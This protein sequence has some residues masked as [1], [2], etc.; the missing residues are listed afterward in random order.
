MHLIPIISAP[1][2]ILILL[3]NASYWEKDCFMIRYYQKI[4]RYPALPATIP[5]K[6]FTDGLAKSRALGGEGFLPRNTPTLINASL[7]KMQFYDMRSTFLED[8][9]KNVVEN[10]DEIHGDMQK[11]VALLYKDS[12]Y[13]EIV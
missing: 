5:K 2:L 8:S 10:K 4:I 13:R 11:A 7:Q 6:A 12:S 3:P 9:V 1:M